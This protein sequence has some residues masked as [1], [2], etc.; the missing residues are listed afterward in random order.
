MFDNITSTE[1]STTE[2]KKYTKILCSYNRI[3][4]KYADQNEMSL[5]KFTKKFHKGEF[6]INFSDEEKQSL[7]ALTESVKSLI[8]AHHI[9]MV[10]K[11]VYD[12]CFKYKISESDQDSISSEAL[13]AMTMAM[14]KYTKSEIKFSTFCTIVVLNQLRNYLKKERGFSRKNWEV[15]KKINDHIKKSNTGLSYNRAIS[16]LA[17]T[18]KE[19]KAAFKVHR[20]ILSIEGSNLEIPK[21]NFGSIEE[22]LE[23]FDHCSLSEVERY[24]LENY[25]FNKS[26]WVVDA[27]NKF[28]HPNGETKTKQYFSSVLRNAKKK[29]K[30][31]CESHDLNEAA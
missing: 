31:Y 27:Q 12:F 11:I 25:V 4:K 16:D 8:V 14:S 19:L 23:V 26:E 2:L 6:K 15:T 21:Q 30:E 1:L 10:K 17:L 24:A 20:V 18:E 29:F 9:N 13:Y 5:R 3:M 7:C 22:L 28:R